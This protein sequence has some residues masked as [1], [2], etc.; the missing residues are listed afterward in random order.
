MVTIDEDERIA[1]DSHDR[2][3]GHLYGCGLT[4]TSVLGRNQLDDGVA[5][6]LHNVIDELDTTIREI[7]NAAY[8]RH[9]HDSDITQ[10]A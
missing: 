8:A 3:I 10:S 5:E 6:R 4:L 2:V 9:F 1:A 7:S